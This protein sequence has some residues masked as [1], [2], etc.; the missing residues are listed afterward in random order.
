MV[1]FVA[2]GGL[3]ACSKTVSKADLKAELDK[4]GL[5]STVDTQCLVD[6]MEAKG[7]VIKNYSEFNDADTKIVTDA[8]LECAKGGPI[9]TPTI[10]GS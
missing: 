9:T 8:T 1:G 6:K 3:A 7:F 5:N 4:A 2:V 10:P